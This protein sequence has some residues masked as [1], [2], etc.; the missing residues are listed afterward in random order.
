MF[1]KEKMQIVDELHKPVRKN[2]PRR[3]TII[4]DYYDY[5]QIDLMEFQP[6]SHLNEG[7]R[8]VLVVIN[9]FSKFVWTRPLKSKTGSEVTKSMKDILES[10]GYSPKNIGSDMGSEFKNSH[11]NSLMK[12]YK[13][14]NFFI[15]SNKKAAIVE[16]VIRTLKN[17]IYKY[18]SLRGAHIWFDILQEITN[19]YNNSKHSTIGMKPCDV[20]PNTLLNVYNVPKIAV[21]R[22]KLNVGDVVRINKYKGV[23]SKGFEI[24][25]SPELFKIVKVNINKPVTFLLE[26]MNGQPIKGCF[27]QQELQKTKLSDIYLVEKVIKQRTKNGV[28]QVLV[29]WLGFPKPTWVNKTDVIL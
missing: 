5:F 21:R 6:Y 12:K 22:K 15:Y 20:K 16:R 10:A 23:F 19:D 7:F 26:D 28:K 3:K 8:Y 2:F 27:Y 17:R 1:S 18:F 29:R 4:K 13:I 25:W 9:C 24:N 14:N 11:F